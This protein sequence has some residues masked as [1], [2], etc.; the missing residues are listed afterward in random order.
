MG[1]VIFFRRV[2]ESIR[3]AK[4][5]VNEFRALISCSF[6]GSRNISSIFKSFGSTISVNEEFL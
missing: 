6:E 3:F 1:K 2:G 5:R 4:K